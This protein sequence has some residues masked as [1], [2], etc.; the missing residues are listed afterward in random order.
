M[1]YLALENR[2]R[3]IAI[4]ITE[5]LFVHPTS[6]SIAPP[7]RSPNQSTGNCSPR[8]EYPPELPG[9]GPRLLRI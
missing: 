3:I 7:N 9:I 1:L 8:N 6:A 4:R 2:S 5:N